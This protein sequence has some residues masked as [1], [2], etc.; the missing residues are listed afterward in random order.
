MV[1]L[2][3]CD[4]LVPRAVVNSNIICFVDCC[5]WYALQ[6]LGIQDVMGFD[7]M[8][9][10]SPQQLSEVRLFWHIVCYVCG[11]GG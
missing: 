6:V 10:P 2:I 3:S 9:P 7:F 5:V 11:S 4:L 8:D 1:N